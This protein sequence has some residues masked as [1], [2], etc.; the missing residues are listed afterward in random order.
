MQYLG[1]KGW[2]KMFEKRINESLQKAYNNALEENKYLREQL[3]K[4]IEDSIMTINEVQDIQ[5]INIS[6][7]EKDMMRNSIINKKRTDYVTKIIEL[8]RSG[9]SSNSK[10]INT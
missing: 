9:K 8:D 7:A 6:E 2:K 3:K 10:N 4:Q 1:R 5:S